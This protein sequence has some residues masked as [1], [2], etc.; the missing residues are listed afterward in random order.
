M[1]HQRLG[2]RLEGWEALEEELQEELQAA[3]QL[4]S[5]S[6]SLEEA[7]WEDQGSDFS[8]DGFVELSVDD[9]VVPEQRVEDRITVLD[10]DMGRVEDPQGIPWSS[11]AVNRDVYRAQRNNAYVSFSHFKRE[12][13]KA[14]QNECNLGSNSKQIYQFHASHRTQQP[15]VP[16]FQ[17]RRLVCAASL[18]SVVFLS[19]SKTIQEF[20]PMA[21]TSRIV[22][23][24]HGNEM[25]PSASLSTI[26]CRD[27]NIAAGTFHGSIYLGRLQD[28]DSFHEI[29]VSQ[30][31]D[32]IVNALIM[33]EDDLIH[34][35]NTGFVAIH[36]LTENRES[37]RFDTAH[38]IN[39]V[40]T[41]PVHNLL[42]LAG[43]STKI[44]VLDQRSGSCVFEL[45]GHTDYAFSSSWHPEG[46]LLATGN[47]D[48][49]TKL[50]DIRRPGAAV[51]TIP[52]SLAAVR[53]CS[54]HT[55]GTLVL[56]EAADY[57]HIL[58]QD[59]AYAAPQQ[60]IEFFGEN[61]GAALSPNA[62]SLYIGI[63]DGSYGCIQEHRVH[64]MTLISDFVL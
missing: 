16:H 54:F 47:Q 18:S 50:W 2:L 36:S 52:S 12:R 58:S 61:A 23:G 14:T 9:T 32:A 6:V 49:T 51:Q 62:T 55:N 64:Q 20:D 28:R 25:D 4:S 15:A 63:A 57:V 19:D 13:T 53:G 38:A 11:L 42:C 37:T 40:S 27:G 33:H 29:H 41:S 26:S 39:H 17:L 35:N 22:L 7:M 1:Q 24:L 8:G 10:M 59:N 31:D 44:D 30:G 5:D 48:C 34:S 46:L 21:N 3:L 60:T 43:D 45:E 56:S